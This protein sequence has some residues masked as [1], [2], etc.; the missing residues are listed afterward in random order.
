MAIAAADNVLVT[1]AEAKAHLEINVADTA[2]DDQVQILINTCSGSI[3]EYCNRILVTNSNVEYHDGRKNNI[4]NLI[5]YP[6]NSVTDVRTAPD[7]DFS[8]A[9][10]IVD[11][12]LYNID[13]SNTALV[14]LSVLPNGHR[15]V[16]VSYE[17]GLG[18]AVGDNLPW[19][20]RF[21]CLEYTKWLW[22][23][24]GDDRVGTSSKSKAGETT[25][26]VQTIP[27]F[28]QQLLEKHVKIDF[29]NADVGIWNG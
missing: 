24:R 15:N 22:K 12:T 23:S 17:S 13:Q 14:F 20:L 16:Q 4:L 21:A 3:A 2:F 8:D 7:S 18:T 1:L 11:S 26:Y 19:S 5:N 29:P 27:E 9:D 25:V 10:T 6:I 28:I